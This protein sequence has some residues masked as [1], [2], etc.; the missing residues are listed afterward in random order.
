MHEYAI[1]LRL[2]PGSQDTVLDLLRRHVVP[3]LKGQPGLV[4]LGLVP[5]PEGDR[6]TILS[7]W[8]DAACAARAEAASGYYLC[9]R[10][11][12]PYL[13]AEPAQQPKDCN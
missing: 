13:I 2:I 3:R 1:T 4:S 8:K 10:R 11:I 12:E 9:L 5:H 6:I 7:I